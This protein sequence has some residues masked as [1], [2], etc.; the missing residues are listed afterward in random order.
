MEPRP[1]LLQEADYSRK[2]TTPGSG[3]LQEADYSRKRTTPGSA[4][5][6][7]AANMFDERGLELGRHDRE[8]PLPWRHDRGAD[9]RGWL[10]WTHHHIPADEFAGAEAIDN[11]D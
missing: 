1:R 6:Q 11:R 3:L 8:R 5:L 7:E 4:L 2:R 10:K 9:D